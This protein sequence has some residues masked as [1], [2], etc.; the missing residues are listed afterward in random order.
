M[1]EQILPS[2]FGYR[3]YKSFKEEIISSDISLIKNLY[4]QYLMDF[5]GRKKA[6]KIFLNKQ[7]NLPFYIS[8]TCTFIVYPSLKSPDRMW[9]N[10]YALESFFIKE[11]ELILRFKSGRIYIIKNDSLKVLKRL[12]EG[13][14]MVNKITKYL[15]TL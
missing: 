9:I 7:R 4:H 10:L 11:G 2:A 15:A 8:K 1:I 3:L 13:K 12:L 5:Q 6:I 14:K